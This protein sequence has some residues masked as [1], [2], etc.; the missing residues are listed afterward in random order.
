MFRFLLK[1]KRLAE[2]QRLIKESRKIEAMEYSLSEQ[3]NDY[4]TGTNKSEADTDS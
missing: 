4:S 3:V 1:I 2:G